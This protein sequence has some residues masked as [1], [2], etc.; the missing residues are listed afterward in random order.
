MNKYFLW[1]KNKKTTRKENA[2]ESVSKARPE[3]VENTRF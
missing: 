3:T 2:G 1:D